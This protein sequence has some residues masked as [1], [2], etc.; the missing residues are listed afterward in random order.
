MK[1]FNPSLRSH[2]ILSVVSGTLV[3]PLTFLESLNFTV[4][5]DISLI[6]I[7]I[8]IIFGLLVM[9]PFQKRNNWFK[10]ILLVLASIGIYTFVV[11][12]AI[13]NYNMFSFHLEHSIGVTVSGG[14]G[15]LL[16]GLAVQFITPLKFQTKVYPLL[17]FVG[18][19]T[20]YIFSFTI[21]SRSAFINS[22]GFIIW[23]TS[24]CFTLYTSKK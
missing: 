10:S 1:F 12:L 18:L 11:R 23:Q 24:V 2:L 15:A 22:I 7:F 21:D 19:I 3:F 13:T 6:D 5:T 16:T 20:G 17:I 9:V 14:L 8:G 4:M